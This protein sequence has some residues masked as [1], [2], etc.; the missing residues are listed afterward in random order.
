MSAEVLEIGHQADVVILLL[1]HA[2]LKLLVFF[3]KSVEFLL[4]LLGLLVNLR[5]L[6]LA[7]LLISGFVFRR[8]GS[9]AGLLRLL[10]LFIIYFL[11]LFAHI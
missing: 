3:Q 5:S 1:C 11:V 2:G 10:L 6:F 8:F 7:F 9:L 4:N